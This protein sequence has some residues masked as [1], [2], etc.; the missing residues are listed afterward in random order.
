MHTFIKEGNR[1]R[2][3]KYEGSPVWNEEAVMASA[4]R[5]A[6]SRTTGLRPFRI[7]IS[8]VATKSERTVSASSRPA[9]TESTSEFGFVYFLLSAASRKMVKVYLVSFGLQERQRRLTSSAISSEGSFASRMR[10]IAPRNSCCEC[11]C[12][13]SIPSGLTES[14]TRLKPLL[15]GRRRKNSSQNPSERS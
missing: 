10:L 1:S 8:I 13:R 12:T 11:P 6:S 4:A 5:T 3:V 15:S 7:V 14:I 9:R 2:C